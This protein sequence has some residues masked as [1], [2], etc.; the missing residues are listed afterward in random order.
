MIGENILITHT[1]TIQQAFKIID[2][3]VLKLALVIDEN[4]YLLVNLRSA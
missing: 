2:V 1:E 4:N 3:E